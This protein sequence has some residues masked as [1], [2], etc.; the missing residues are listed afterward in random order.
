M[1]HLDTDWSHCA[2]IIEVGHYVNLLLMFCTAACSVW[3][4]VNRL[5]CPGFSRAAQGGSRV[6]GG[7]TVSFFFSVFAGR[8]CS[9]WPAPGL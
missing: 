2:C 4:R 7:V 6:V 3:R 8:P 9:G 1:I 5:S